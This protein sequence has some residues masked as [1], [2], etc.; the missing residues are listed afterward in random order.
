MPKKRII[1]TTTPQTQSS[2]NAPSNPAN[3]PNFIIGCHN[4]V[5]GNGDTCKFVDLN[6]VGDIVAIVPT[7]QEAFD[8]CYQN[9]DNVG[10][11]LLEYIEWSNHNLAPRVG[12]VGLPCHEFSAAHTNNKDATLKEQRL[13]RDNSDW[14]FR[15]KNWTRCGISLEGSPAWT[16]ARR[17]TRRYVIHGKNSIIVKDYYHS[18]VLDTWIHKEFFDSHNI[19]EYRDFEQYMKD[20]TFLRQHGGLGGVWQGLQGYR[21]FD[22][23]SQS[24]LIKATEYADI[25]RSGRYVTYDK[26]NWTYTNVVTGIEKPLPGHDAWWHDIRPGPSVPIPDDLQSGLTR[27]RFYLLKLLDSP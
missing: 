20:I 10:I 8:L 3:P 5:S 18:L 27:I 15:Q 2:T 22:S 19:W 4:K 14:D 7:L 11:T 12:V 21:S 13:Y 24:S 26:S 17:S 9:K 1:H 25:L 23:L 16:H 6:L